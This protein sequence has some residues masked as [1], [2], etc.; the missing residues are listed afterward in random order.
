MEQTRHLQPQDLAKL[1]RI[2]AGSVWKKNHVTCKWR[3]LAC[4]HTNATLFWRD[5]SA[6]TK[7]CPIRKFR[8]GEIRHRKT[9]SSH[10]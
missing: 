7:P 4:L 8:P 5:H 10:H 9:E 2:C 3:C 6:P 1:I